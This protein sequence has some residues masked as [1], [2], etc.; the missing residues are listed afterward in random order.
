MVFF[1]PEM[2]SSTSNSSLISDDLSSNPLY[3]HIG[4][5]PGSRTYSGS[6][7]EWRQLQCLESFNDHGA[8]CKEQNCIY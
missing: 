5:S 3:L 1:T 8:Y 7:L 2:S 6:T 4:D